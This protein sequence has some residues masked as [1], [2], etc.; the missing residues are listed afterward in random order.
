MTSPAQ[1]EVFACQMRRCRLLLSVGA[2]EQLQWKLGGQL[3]R[4]TLQGPPQEWS[5]V[6]TNTWA[7]LWGLCWDVLQPGSGASGGAEV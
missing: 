4:G 7:A 5:A 6:C 2:A 3:G 1:L